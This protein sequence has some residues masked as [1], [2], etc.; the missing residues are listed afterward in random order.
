M[1]MWL[2]HNG[3]RQV[4]RLTSLNLRLHLSC[5]IRQHSSKPSFHIGMS[6]RDLAQPIWND[7]YL[8][9]HGAYIQI[10]FEPMTKWGKSFLLMTSIIGN[11]IW[12][13]LGKIYLNRKSRSTLPLFGILPKETMTCLE[14]TSLYISF[15]AQ[16]NVPP[17]SLHMMTPWLSDSHTLRLRFYQ[18]SRAKLNSC[19]LS[20]AK[21]IV[22]L[23]TLIRHVPHG[24]EVG[25][26]RTQHHIDADM[27]KFSC[28]SSHL[29][30]LSWEW[31][32]ME[33]DPINF[34]QHQSSAHHPDKYRRQT[35][36]QVAHTQRPVHQI[37]LAQCIE[38]PQTVQIDFSQVIYMANELTIFGPLLDQR[39]PQ[40]LQAPEVTRHAFE[41]LIVAHDIPPRAFHF[42]T[43]GSKALDGHVG[44]GIVLLIETAIG[45]QF[46]GCLYCHIASATSSL[47][48]EHGALIWALIWAVHLSHQ[49]W[50]AH[51]GAPLAF[52]FNFD[53]TVS[54]N[55]AAG[56]WRTIHALSWRIVMR[57]LAQILQTRHGH[58]HVAWHHIKAH[59]GH[60]WNECAD[61]LAKYA[62]EHPQQAQSSELWEAWTHDEGKLCALQWIWYKELM[63]WGDPRVPLLQNG[64]MICIVPRPPA[65][66]DEQ[67]APCNSAPPTLTR[68][69]KLTFA[70]ANVMTLDQSSKTT[71]VT[72]RMLLMQQFHTAKCTIVG[73][74][75]TRHKHLACLNNE[76]YHIFGHAADSRGQDGVQIWISKLLPVDNEGNT[77]D[78]QLVRV[79]AAAPNYMIV[80]LKIHG[81]TLAVI[82]GRA[83][84]SGRPR[85]EAVHF[86]SN[87]QTI[88]QK[89][90][91]GLPIFFCGDA[92]AHLGESPTDS[93][94]D[95]QPAQENQAGQVF[96]EWLLHQN[97]FAPSTF[98]HTH[99]GEDVSTFTS[100]TGHEVRIDYVAIPQHL[101]YDYV[102]A[103]TENEIDLTLSR[104]DHKAALCSLVLQV[105]HSTSERPQRSLQPD[106][107][108]LAH[109]LEEAYNRHYLHQAMV[110]PSWNVD[111][112]TSASILAHSTRQAVRSLAQPKTQWRR[113]SHITQE[114]W[115]FG[116]SQKAAVQTTTMPETHLALYNIACM[117]SWMEGLQ[118]WRCS[119]HQCHRC[120]PCMVSSSWSCPLQRHSMTCCEQLQK[121]K[122]PFD[123][124]TVNITRP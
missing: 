20:I 52:S 64:H 2:H 92:N 8:S 120:A 27:D 91:A 57:S 26:S 41:G 28:W 23:A 119:D 30:N 61:S 11:C 10:A 35:V 84:H 99:R 40:D 5:R 50:Q 95:F 63:E 86:W 22:L 3:W 109:N 105:P 16:L 42:F 1:N 114:T 55:M 7:S 83:P 47:Y 110:T 32:D 118:I 96:H 72:R 76:Y 113:K 68:E 101:H 13:A 18:A 88:A 102:Q 25:N 82:T 34:L 56:R 106:V 70:T 85:H 107:Q 21:M 31:D 9:T 36:G 112:H 43:D 44:S 116:R 122:Q 108:D 123:T 97:L 45:W 79:V 87:L 6:M 100:P 58:D 77:I 89:K 17:W 33:E 60:P 78:K 46:G 75:E 117:F 94:G 121:P 111:P 37:E 65:S 48:G 69:V 24:K 80:K 104:C 71:S 4:R 29:R 124:K 14:F 67:F 38:P 19:K 54:G 51:P 81:W 53:A 39:W 98:E 49:H 15:Y 115:G 74:Q 59:S 93:V 12:E 66:T 73:I 103:W 90:L 62:A